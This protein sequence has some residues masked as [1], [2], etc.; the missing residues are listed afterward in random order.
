MRSRSIILLVAVMFLAGTGVALALAPEKSTTGPG[1][2]TTGPGKSTAGPAKSPSGP[3]RPSIV[4][5][6]FASGTVKASSTGSFTVEG[7]EQGKDREWTFVLDSKTRIVKSGKPA[8]ATDV[9][10]GD[11][12]TVKYT[13]QEG[14]AVA[15]DVTVRPKPVATAS[16]TVKSS[17][18]DSLVVGG[19]AQAGTGE[20]T[21]VLDSKTRIVRSGKTATATDVEA[22]DGVTVKYT[23]QEGKAVAQ[24]VTVRPKPVA[25][26]SGTVKPSSAGRLVVAGKEYG[27]DREWTFVLDSKTRFVK[28]GKPATATDIKTDDLVTVRYTERGGKAVA[29]D[30]TVQQLVKTAS[31][32]VKSSSADS[33]VVTGRAQAVTGELTFV[34]DSKTHITRNRKPATATDLQVG[35]LVIVGYTEQEGKAVAKD[36]N[37]VSR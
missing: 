4:P 24:D 22:G 23:E 8:T 31:G 25:T 21:F 1:K 27:K 7:K 37:A 35:D 20:L 11:L 12:V 16:G 9:E 33:L 29:Q 15:Q 14:K 3:V 19:Q 13:E 30:V 36:V 28:G 17:S 26:A 32:T 10:A 5:A 2:S 34:L 6:R 18:A